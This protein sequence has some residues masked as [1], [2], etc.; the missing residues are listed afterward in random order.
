MTPCQHRVL[1][2]VDRLEREQGRPVPALKLAITLQA[3][4][5]AERNRLDGVVA[6]LCQH[7]LL[8]SRQ[9][10]NGAGLSLNRYGRMALTEVRKG[11]PMALSM[12]ACIDTYAEQ[13]RQLLDE[14]RALEDDPRAGPALFQRYL[15]GK[16][17]LAE[18][19]AAAP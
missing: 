14:I 18:W 1:E 10:E 13:A 11:R 6:D 2:A 16:A 19:E 12:T 17:L 9:V 15:R 3:A 5:A 4:T 8:A 7:E